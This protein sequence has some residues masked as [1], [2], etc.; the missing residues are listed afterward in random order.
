MS[1][2]LPV[3]PNLSEGNGRPEKPEVS[4]LDASINLANSG[5]L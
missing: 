1:F 3:T 5:L 4:Q 2:A